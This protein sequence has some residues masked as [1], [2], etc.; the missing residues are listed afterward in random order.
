MVFGR[1]EKENPPF[2]KQ[3]GRK[4]VQQMTNSTA[5]IAEFCGEHKKNVTVVTFPGVEQQLHG[6]YMISC[7]FTSIVQ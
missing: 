5:V 2:A 3:T 1:K 4:K 6:I 7:I